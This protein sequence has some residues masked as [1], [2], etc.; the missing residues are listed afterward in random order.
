MKNK[1]TITLIV[2]ALAASI[3]TASAQTLVWS[4]TTFVIGP[5][6]WYT[7]GFPGILQ[8]VNEQLIVTE[9]HFGSAISNPSG[10][11][12]PGVHTL[13]SFGALPDHQTLELRTDLVSANLPGRRADLARPLLC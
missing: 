11:H 6:E 5:T 4:D 7:G 8:S 2:L 9:N 12:L 10:T 1:T 13:P 3:S